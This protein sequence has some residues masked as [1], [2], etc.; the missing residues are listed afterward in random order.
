MSGKNWVEENLF[1]TGGGGPE[2]ATAGVA[3]G[4][5]ETAASGFRDWIAALR[6]GPAQTFGDLEFHPMIAAGDGPA[7]WLTAGEAVE[8]GSLVIVE[9]GGGAVGELL[10][11]N[12]GGRPVLILEGE[13]LVGC[14]QNRVVAHTVMVAPGRT[15]VIPVGCME[16]GRWSSARGAFAM[17][18]AR[19]EPSL[20]KET[21]VET[22]RARR[23]TG[24][25]AL[26]Q[27]RLWQGVADSENLHGT[28]SATGDYHETLQRREAETREAVRRAEPLASQVGIVALWRGRLLGLESVGHPEAWNAV[29]RR[30]IASYVLAAGS[31]G[32]CERGGAGAPPGRSAAEWLEAV[33][34]ARITVRPALDVGRD[35]ELT[36]PGFVGSALWHDGAPAHLSVFSA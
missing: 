16:Q 6:L 4:R 10:A 20:R 8:K 11:R 24:R 2:S 23:V 15:V 26:D 29:A 13:T 33:R 7:A 14:K 19:M 17:G 31:L 22:A 25:P 5:E 30:T 28:R 3:G 1:K 34:T 21:V 36:G 27:L 12:R 32:R 18:A 9:Q 35:L